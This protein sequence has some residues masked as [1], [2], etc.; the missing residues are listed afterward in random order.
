LVDFNCLIWD[1]VAVCAE[2]PVLINNTN[3]RICRGKI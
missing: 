1:F 3:L 2:Q